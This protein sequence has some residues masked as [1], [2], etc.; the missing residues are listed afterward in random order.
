MILRNIKDRYVT[1]DTRQ[2]PWLKKLR[3]FS[4]KNNGLLVSDKSPKH[5]IH[6]FQCIN[7]CF[8]VP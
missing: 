1:M 6:M 3:H 4:I 7:R 2:L 5:N 8:H